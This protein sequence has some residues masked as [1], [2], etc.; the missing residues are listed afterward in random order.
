M[1]TRILIESTS[2]NANIAY[3]AGGKQGHV[4]K[5]DAAHVMKQ[6]GQ[7]GKQFNYNNQRFVMF[8]PSDGGLQKPSVRVFYWASSQDSISGAIASFGDHLREVGYVR[9]ERLTVPA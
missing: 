2:F 7:G 6:A 3:N 4:S 5:E 9:N 1:T 8:N